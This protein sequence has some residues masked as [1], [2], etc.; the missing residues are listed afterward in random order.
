AEMSGCQG[1]HAL[2]TESDPF[3]CFESTLPAY[4][5]P[6]LRR[7]PMFIESVQQIP[8]SLRGQCKCRVSGCQGGDIALLTEGGPFSRF[9]SINIGPTAGARC[10]VTG[11]LSDS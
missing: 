7:R 9:E 5:G 2:L 6:G 1:R 11:C 3:S 10:I 4:G 8:P